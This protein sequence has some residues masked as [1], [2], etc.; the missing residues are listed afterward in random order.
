MF[1]ASVTCFWP[2]S[3]PCSLLPLS[4]LIPSLL[5]SFIYMRLFRVIHFRSSSLNDCILIT[6]SQQ[7]PFFTLYF[8][9]QVHDLSKNLLVLLSW[10]VALRALVFT[11][12]GVVVQWTC[13]RS[14]SATHSIMYYA[15]T[16][17]LPC[18]CF[19][20]DQWS[21][22]NVFDFADCLHRSSEKPLEGAMLHSITHTVFTGEQPCRTHGHCKH[23]FITAKSLGGKFWSLEYHCDTQ[24][25]TVM[26]VVMVQQQQICHNLNI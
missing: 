2:L 9:T 7:Y 11:V 5:S 19:L 14:W 20:Y 26:K 18:R 22:I 3:P 17:W 10:S 21:Y 24:L 15:A 13:R 6:T 4:Y 8:E 12:K 23:S 16:V 25:C 1:S